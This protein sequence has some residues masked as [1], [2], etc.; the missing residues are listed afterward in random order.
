METTSGRVREER[1]VAAATVPAESPMPAVSWAAI[2]AGAFA[3][4]AISLILLA[5]GAGL[6]FASVSPWSNSNPSATTF[7][8]AAGIWLIV[9]QWLSAAFGGYLTGRLRTKWVSVPSH[10]IY[11]R[12]TAHGFLAWGVAAVITVAVLASAT[13]TLVGGIGRA[14]G[15]ANASSAQGASGSAASGSAATAL[16]PTP[17]LINE[18]FRS[19]HPDVNGNFQT[20][21][22]EATPIV[23]RALGEGSMPAGD[24]TYL[25]ALVAARTGLSQPDAA[26]RVDD[27][28]GQIRAIWT[29]AHQTADRA[30]K[31]ASDVLLFTAFSMLIGAF[32]AAVAATVAGHR[33]DQ[34]LAFRH[35]V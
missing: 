4:A 13:S 33:R 21:S 3:M 10:E 5:L 27:V 14:A 34:V 20:P 1:I 8:I 18:L 26:K 6:G 11:F 15:T 30:R 9:V 35:P 17:Y 29:K 7:G 22:A 25:A 32:I 2:I 12:D 31:A 23:A 28:D 24:K 19:D 16:D